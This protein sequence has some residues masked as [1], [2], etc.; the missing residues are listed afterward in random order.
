MEEAAA[1]VSTTGASGVGTDAA[2]EGTAG[3]AARAVGRAA[4]GRGRT[5]RRILPP[6]VI[7]PLV[8]GRG[9]G[10]RRNEVAGR[11]KGP[12]KSGDMSWSSSPECLI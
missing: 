10:G 11:G 8:V 5:G 7:K 2:G 4:R 1:G 12:L 9:K 6:F 3:A